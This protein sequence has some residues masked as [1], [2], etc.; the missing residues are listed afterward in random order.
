[1]PGIYLL[2]F[3][4]SKKTKNR[5]VWKR[6]GRAAGHFEIY[7]TAS[8]LLARK[9]TE[10]LVRISNPIESMS[11]LKMK[12]VTM[13]TDNDNPKDTAKKQIIDLGNGSEVIYIQRFIPF[14]QSWK[15]FD[16]LDEHI[17]WTRPTIRVFGK[18]FIQV[19]FFSSPLIPI[20]RIH[21][22]LFETSEKCWNWIKFWDSPAPPQIFFLV[23][24]CF[25]LIRLSISV[26][27]L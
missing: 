16:Y 14:D 7:S 8:T 1:M 12:A 11:L 21:C 13:A 18:S 22:C 26:Y 3:V 2:V 10:L 15:W 20:Y 27:N 5:P 9:E 24:F 25:L 17:P 6:P 4:L 19:S 23:L